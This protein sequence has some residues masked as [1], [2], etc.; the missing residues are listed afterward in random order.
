MLDSAKA[1]GTGVHCHGQVMPLIVTGKTKSKAVPGSYTSP[2]LP[3]I[4][5]ETGPL[6]TRRAES[7]ISMSG[8]RG[9][10]AFA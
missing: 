9:Q 5:A 8:T 1:T 4:Q 6:L 10:G 2:S 7:R 3:T